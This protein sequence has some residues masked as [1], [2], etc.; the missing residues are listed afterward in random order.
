[1]SDL[2]AKTTEHGGATFTVANRLKRVVWGFAYTVLFRPSPRPAHRWRA[3][4]LRLFGATIGQGVHVY[5][6]VKIWAPWNLMIGDDVG[7]GDD[8]TLYSMAT[9][10]I[11]ARATVSQGAYLCCGTHD[12]N[13]PTMQLITKPIAVGAEAWVCAEAFVCPG[14]T[15]GE[16]GVVGARAVVS[17]NIPDWTVWAGNPCV[18]RG[19]RKRHNL[20]EA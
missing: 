14:V 18:Q 11:G 10:T 6:K 12:Y 16:G 1:M 19:T 8:A 9:I 17:K 4:L 13:D 5:P 2:L 3:S 20:P 15:I 7:V